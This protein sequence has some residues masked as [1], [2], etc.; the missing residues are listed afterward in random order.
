[1][2]TTSTA[3]FTLRVS[4]EDKEKFTLLSILNNKPISKI[5]KELVDKELKNKK[6]TARDIRKLPPDLRKKILLK[7]TEDSLPVYNKYKKELFLDETG[8]GIE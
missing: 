4:K 7:M 2:H 3:L 5:V 6:L 1:M 8:D